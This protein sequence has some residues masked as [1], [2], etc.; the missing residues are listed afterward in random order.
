MLLKAGVT[1][2]CSF[3]LLHSGL[4]DEG[5]QLLKEFSGMPHIEHI[6][7]PDPG[8]PAGD[9]DEQFWET[10]GQEGMAQGFI[11]DIQGLLHGK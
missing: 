6:D 5:K 8:P 1:L 4:E 7:A 11:D 3:L 2:D 9:E 10:V